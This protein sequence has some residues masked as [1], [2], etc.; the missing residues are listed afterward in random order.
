MQEVGGDFRLGRRLI[1]SSSTR[2]A[3][4]ADHEAA[5]SGEAGCRCYFTGIDQDGYRL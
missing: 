4:I 5:D 2:K 1:S 3:E